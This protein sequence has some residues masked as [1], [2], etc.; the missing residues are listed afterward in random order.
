MNMVQTT[1][2]VNQT[3]AKC[4]LSVEEG[5]TLA[6][7][8]L[9]LSILGTT[10]NVLVCLS[11][12]LTPS[13]Q[14]VSNWF[15]FSMAVSD[16]LNALIVAP[17]QSVLSLSYVHSVCLT[18]IKKIFR[19]VSNLSGSSSLTHLCFI[20]LERCVAI[21]KPFT[22]NEIL[23]GRKLT[24]MFSLAWILPLIYTNLRLIVAK[25]YTS[26]LSVTSYFGFYATILVSYGCIFYNVHKERQRIREFSMQG[27]LEK[28]RHDLE[29]RLAVTIAVVILVIN[30]TW[31]PLFYYR[32]RDPSVSYGL[33]YECA[34]T[35]V[36]ASAVLN[37]VI[38]NMRSKDFR[39]AT[40]RIICYCC[41][42]VNL[43]RLT[44]QE[45]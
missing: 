18:E 35:L 40:K 21:L 45:T 25:S 33:G 20:S 15:L 19:F 28:V 11:I 44:V 1:G 24:A 10:G 17:L 38:Y 43:L 5:I 3:E 9:T 41:S 42:K 8:N 13:L 37:P 32:L 23:C 16:L 34:R 36:V 4:S 39:R 22:Y 14:V 6:A 31:V 30:V 27:R 12:I 7:I 26:Y 2:I 29:K